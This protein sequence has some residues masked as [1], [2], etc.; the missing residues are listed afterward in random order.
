MRYCFVAI[1]V[2]KGFYQIQLLHDPIVVQIAGNAVHYG[3]FD[4]IYKL[5]HYASNS[6]C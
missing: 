4:G 2:V 5:N 6:E 1:S 3:V